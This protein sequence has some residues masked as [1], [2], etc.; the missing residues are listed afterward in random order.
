MK[1]ENRSRKQSHKLDGIG[2][3]R[4]TTFPFL[5]IP[6]T[7]PLMIQRKLVCRSRK[8]KRKNQPNAKRGIKYCHWFIL[9]LLLAT[10]RMQFSLDRK[11]QRHKQNHC[12]ASDSVSLIFT[13]SYCSTLLITT[14]T[15]T[16][17]LV[18]TSL[19]TKR[20]WGNNIV[21]SNIFN[22]VTDPNKLHIIF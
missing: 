7:T 4:I 16:P 11:Q 2:V 9:L 22:K 15:T 14:L 13:G 17:L 5:P 21:K 3:R 6:F 12:S 8:Q 20:N 1:I 18:K 19:K 10:P